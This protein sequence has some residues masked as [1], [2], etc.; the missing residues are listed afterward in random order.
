MLHSGRVVYLDA[1]VV[2]LR[3]PRQTI[4]N[5]PVKSAKFG[6]SIPWETV[7][8]IRVAGT[9]DSQNKL[10]SNE[11]IRINRRTNL[12]QKMM[13][14]MGLLGL[15]TSFLIGSAIQESM[16]PADPANLTGNHGRARFSFWTTVLAGTAASIGAGYRMGKLLDNKYS[17]NRI[18]RA[19]AD[20]RRKQVETASIPEHEGV[21]GR[22]IA[23]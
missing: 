14:N 9:L 19:R 4:T 6:T 16:A 11:E 3:T 7:K 15:A 17:V 13:A 8:S 12:R 5:S 23:K 1:K 20:L 22:P 21:Y 2:V 18:E 10:I